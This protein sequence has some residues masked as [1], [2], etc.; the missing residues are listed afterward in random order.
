MY[1]SPQ[2]QKEGE[3]NNRQTGKRNIKES[4]DGVHPLA[5]RSEISGVV[6]NIY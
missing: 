6:K 3:K 4:V 5:G 1:F 2:I